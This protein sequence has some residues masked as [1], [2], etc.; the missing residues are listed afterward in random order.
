MLKSRIVIHN[1]KVATP[2]IITNPW[3]KKDLRYCKK[4]LPFEFL[5]TKNLLVEKENEIDRKLEINP[6][7]RIDI[8]S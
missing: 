8:L 1:H 3:V 4:K 7:N 2:I 6:I 5:K